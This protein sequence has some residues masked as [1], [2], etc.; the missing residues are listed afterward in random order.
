MCYK[1]YRPDADYL[2]INF[3]LGIP[4][5]DS[6][7]SA[8]VIWY[9]GDLK[10]AVEE[11]IGAEKLNCTVTQLAPRRLRLDGAPSSVNPILDK[12]FP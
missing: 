12:L 8:E 7:L 3:T 5:E 4:V 6:Q 1:K 11:Q 2:K 9:N 10:S